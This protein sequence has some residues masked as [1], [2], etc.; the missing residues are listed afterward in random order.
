MRCFA[1][2]SPSLPPL[3]YSPYLPPPIS[4]TSSS[5]NPPPSP[6]GQSYLGLLGASGLQVAVEHLLD[7]VGEQ[8]GDDD[9]DDGEP[10]RAAGEQLDE[11]KV[12]V[13]G[14]EE[15]P[16]GGGVRGQEGSGVTQP[17]K[18]NTAVSG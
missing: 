9:D 7:D 11:D 5:S 15:G 16:G 3:K 18:D 1:Q 8:A 13:L 6:G 4:Q 10:G 14:V 17:H 12:H 2:V